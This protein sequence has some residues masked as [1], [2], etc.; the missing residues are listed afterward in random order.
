LETL[1]WSTKSKKTETI[2]KFRNPTGVT[3]ASWVESSNSGFQQVGP[4]KFG[5]VAVDCARSVPDGSCATTT[6]GS[7]IEPTTV[8]AT[9]PVPIKAMTQQIPRDLPSEGNH[10]QRSPQS[11]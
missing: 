7:I 1:E 11:K 3:S 6:D 5:I 2:V 4:E 10:R 8:E 9:T